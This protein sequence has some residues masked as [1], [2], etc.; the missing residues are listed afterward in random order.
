MY[1][2]KAITKSGFFFTPSQPDSKHPGILTISE[3]GRAEIE[4]T[5]KTVAFS[6]ANEMEIGWLIGEV[7]GGYVTL[8]GCAYRKISLAFGSPAKSLIT[9]DAVY[10]G[11]GF[12]KPPTFASVDFSVDGLSE[13]L[14][15][16]AFKIN[17]KERFED[18]SIT[19]EQ[20]EPISCKLPDET[21]LEI[22]C[23]IKIPGSIKYPIIE[24]FQQA[25]ITVTPPQ[26]MTLR[27][28]QKLSHQIT[29]FFSFLIGKSAAIHSMVGETADDQLH[30]SQKKV[31]IYFKSLNGTTKKDFSG[32]DMLLTYS[33]LGSKFVPLLSAWMKNY[34]KLTPALHH[35]YSLQDD[36]HRYADTKFIAIAQAIEA[37]HRRTHNTL[38][39]PK[40]EYRKKLKDILGGCPG[41]DR[42][43]LNSKLAHGNEITLAERAHELTDRFGDIFGG[44]SKVHQIVRG[45]VNTRNY[46]AHYDP[47]GERKALKGAALVGLT[48]S[49]QAVFILSILVHLGY[50]VTEAIEISKSPY[51]HR[52]LTTAE[53]LRR[54]EEVETN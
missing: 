48:Y 44:E 35:H 51:L 32:H 9:A 42:D 3:G 11:I 18:H 28:Y 38:K 45:L 39:W 4:I 30:H 25:Y 29:R 36:S 17:I 14:G 21:S 40:E 47:E 10:E 6:T 20:Q 8:E 15:R 49:L 16:S 50:T 26:P 22:K 1:I 53:S 5:A 13:W 54:A 33:K 27:H 37:L 12:T 34:D 19:I 23:E 24:L 31:R 41:T 7:E 2:S 43:W 52:I 46:H